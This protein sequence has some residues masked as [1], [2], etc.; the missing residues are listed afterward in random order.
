MRTFFF[1]LLGLILFWGFKNNVHENLEQMYVCR[2]LPVELDRQMNIIESKVQ[3]AFFEIFSGCIIQPW[4]DRYDIQGPMDLSHEVYSITR[5]CG[6][7]EERIKA[8]YRWVTTHIAYDTDYSIYTAD[9]CYRE[10]KGVCMA[11]SQLLVKMLGCIGIPAIV[12]RGEVRNEGKT[13]YG[14]HAWVMID[15][16]DG[17]YLLAD[18]TWDAGGVDAVT[19]KFI[20][21]PS[22]K[23]FDC[24][25]EVMIRTHFP[26]SERH[27]LLD[28]P[29]SRGDFEGMS[30]GKASAMM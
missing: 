30:H 4:N 10:R 6:N 28:V 16:G 14:R 22:W 1:F 13:G 27:Q 25:P 24:A 3:K 19:G 7:R 23:W 21:S 18:P 17:D 9:E 8:V 20:S 29:V 15:R 2:D 5:D 12:V 26:D 11:Y